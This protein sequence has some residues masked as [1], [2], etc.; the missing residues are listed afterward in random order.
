VAAVYTVT[1]GGIRVACETTG[2]RDAP[3]MVLLHALGERGV[4]WAPVIA[5]FAERFLVVTLDLRGHGDTDWPGDYSLQL[6]REDV[7]GV[8]DHLGLDA[9]TLVGHSMGGAVAYLV[10]IHHPSRVER[11][12]VED[13]SPPFPRDRAIPER[14][15]DSLDFDWSV[16]PAIVGQVNAGDPDAWE[17][18]AA[19]TAPTLLIGGGPAS[20]IPQDKLDAVAA[21]VPDCEL[22]TIPAGHNVHET[23]PAEYADAVLDWVGSS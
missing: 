12:I 4:S 18:L 21:R 7:I 1:P 5:R 11:L 20:H 13:V 10:A 3:P 17:G 15:S 8:L 19:I 2:S 22:I 16:V 6:M 23:R 14:P 9:V